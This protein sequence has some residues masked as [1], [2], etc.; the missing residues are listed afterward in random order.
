MNEYI[1][2]VARI[3][4]R[5][6]RRIASRKSLY[7]LMIVLPVILF[8]A[9]AAIYR[10]EVV[11]DLPVAVLDGDHSEISRTIVRAVASDRLFKIVAEVQSVSA[12]EEGIRAGRIQGAFYLPKG[13]ERNIKR[14]EPAR[15]VVYRNHINLLSGNMI[16]KEGVTISRTI[17]AG[18]LMKKLGSRGLGAGQAIALANPV[19]VDAQP[20][21]N[22]AYNYANYLVPGLL[23]ALMQMLI[24][25][26]AVLVISAEYHEGTLPGLFRMAHGRAGAVLLGK[27][28]PHLLLHGATALGL[29]GIIF[30]LFHI[31]VAGSIGQL[32]ALMLL[33][34][35]A[36]FFLGLMISTLVHNQMLATEAAVFINTPAFMFSGYTYP[37]WGM[38]G[39]HQLFAQIMPFTHFL[40][41]F[42]KVYQMGAPLRALRHEIEILASFVLITVLVS[43]AVLHYRGRHLPAP[44]P[45]ASDREGGAR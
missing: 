45:I 34:I 12:I 22:P 16:Y 26:V 37:L 43:W 4:A 18:I 11:K 9:V 19:S 20:L 7:L 35:A 44:G 21:F 29:I 39:I 42:I 28:L 13:M 30:P 27:S 24:M 41:A 6:W 3:M 32:F 15:M 5:E 1:Q 38:P 36:S 14:G 17:S 2:A 10:S 40:T 8:L 23:P 33:F 25:L 31:P